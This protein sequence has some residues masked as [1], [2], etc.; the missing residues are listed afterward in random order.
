LSERRQYRNPPIEEALCEIK[1]HGEPSWDVT[2]PGLLYERLRQSYPEKPQQA[3]FLEAGIQMAPGAPGPSLHFRQDGGRVQFRDSSGR[4]LLAVGP[5][6]LSTHVLRPY[7]GWE[8]FRPRIVEA[9]SAYEEVAQPESVARI[10]IRY[11]NRIVVGAEVIEIGNYFT[12]GPE[13]P[14]SLPQ[15]FVGFL[16]RLDAVFPDSQTHLVVTFASTESEDEGRSAFILDLDVFEEFG[17]GEIEISGCGAEVD[18][19]RGL[20]REA[21]EDLITDAARDL[22]D[23]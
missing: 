16:Q 22:F 21:F 14:P 15:N 7:P 6:V 13:M 10:G 17:E 9:I 18:R 12:S 11:I 1:F 5:G 23:A 8:A 19:L 2:I 3:G 4:A 20:E